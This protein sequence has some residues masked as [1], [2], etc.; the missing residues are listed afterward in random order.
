M[1]CPRC[2][3]PALYVSPD[4]QLLGCGA[5]RRVCQLV[6]VKAT[7]KSEDKITALRE[8]QKCARIEE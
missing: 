2:K 1:Y 3:M 7:T 5:C 4:G 8:Q 6:E